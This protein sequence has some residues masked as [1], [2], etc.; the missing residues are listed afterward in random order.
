VVWR[1]S[2]KIIG[3]DGGAKGRRSE[4]TTA[5]ISSYK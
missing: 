4:A 1:Y 3:E 2:V 5:F